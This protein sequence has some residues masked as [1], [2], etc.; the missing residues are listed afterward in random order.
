MDIIQ[1]DIV[2]SNGYDFMKIA[3]ELSVCY[4]MR[5]FGKNITSRRVIDCNYLKQTGPTDYSCLQKCFLEACSK[6]WATFSQTGTN[7]L[8]AKAEQMYFP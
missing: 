2:Y 7:S 3:F 4:S 6:S 8:L 5:F 1:L